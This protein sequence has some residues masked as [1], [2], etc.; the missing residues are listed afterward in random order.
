M[1]RTSSAC[2]RRS[3][4]SNRAAYLKRCSRAPAFVGIGRVCLAVQPG[5]LLLEVEELAQ[6]LRC[7][8]GSH[9]I[10]LSFNPC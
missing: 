2:G 4:F 5:A 10:S 7:G 9:F 6:A 3:S 1:S 8:W